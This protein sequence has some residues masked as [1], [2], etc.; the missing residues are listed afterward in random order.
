LPLFN[1][2]LSIMICL[3]ISGFSLILLGNIKYASI[4]LF[5][6]GLVLAFVQT[7]H[8]NFVTD[9]S[10]ANTIKITLSLI[11]EKSNMPLFAAFVLFCLIFSTRLNKI[12]NCLLLLFSMGIFLFALRAS[13]LKA[14]I[15]R[16]SDGFFSIS[17]LELY[18][19][20]FI[21]T[22]IIFLI[23][24]EVFNASAFETR[25]PQRPYAWFFILL[26]LL[27]LQIRSGNNW[28]PITYGKFAIISMG[29]TNESK[30]TF[31]DSQY[32]LY[33]NSNPSDP[34]IWYNFL[35]Y[36][37]NKHKLKNSKFNIEIK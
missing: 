6:S 19:A 2:P 37:I 34:L 22:T 24:L 13:L 36:K 10:A 33:N 11:F 8:H 16:W 28:Y 31:G 32:V 20:P 14:G 26:C 1:L 12:E 5:V 4:P 18:L 9:V 23:L 15:T 25:N 27:F 17:C 35:K 21:Y 29:K 7:F 30:S 3:I